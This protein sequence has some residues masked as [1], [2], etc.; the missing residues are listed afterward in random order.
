MVVLFNGKADGT[1]SDSIEIE[2]FA[3]VS[4]VRVI[5]EEV[6]TMASADV[7]PGQEERWSLFTV[8]KKGQF[9]LYF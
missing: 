8:H 2:C 1:S 4:V 7:T 6:M 3:D 5:L 9:D